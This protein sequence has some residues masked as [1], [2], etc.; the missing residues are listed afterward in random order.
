MI[1]KKLRW[2]QKTVVVIGYI[3]RF[4]LQFRR[5]AL[6]NPDNKRA[7]ARGYLVR[8]PRVWVVDDLSEGFEIGVD[9]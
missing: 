6:R 5:Q 4:G 8:Y 3:L 1:S 2:G 7:W 9:W